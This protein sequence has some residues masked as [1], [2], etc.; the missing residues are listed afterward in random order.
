MS[1]KFIFLD[2][3]LVHRIGH[4]YEY[5]LNIA[6][7]FILEGWEVIFFSNKKSTLSSMAGSPVFKH[8]SYTPTDKI[9]NLKI[10]RPLIKIFAHWRVTGNELQRALD[11]MDN[12]NSIFF[13]QHV[14]CYM[15]PGI[16]Q[17][18][19]N[20]KGKLVLMLRIT[21]ENSNGQ[22]TLKSVLYKVFLYLL[23][24]Y[25]KEKLILVT[26]SQR[27]LSEFK[28]LT[29]HEIYLL[30]IPNI[31][32]VIGYREQQKSKLTVLLAG[33]MSFEKGIQYI[34][35]LVE[36]ARALNLPLNFIIHLYAPPNENEVY[37]SI[38]SKMESLEA[39]DLILTKLPLSSN[40]Y[41]D[42]IKSADIMLLLYDGYRYR[43]QTSGLFLDALSFGLYPIVSADTWLADMVSSSCFGTVIPKNNRVQSTLSALKE[44]TITRNTLMPPEALELLEWH[45]SKTFYST[46]KNLIS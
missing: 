21:A 34:P 36:A 11:R 29:K 4:A 24:N 2:P 22:L 19:F 8:F 46:L 12:F 27:L 15:L 20:S 25:L 42:Q 16:F 6:K 3:S 38:K 14:E 28:K 31:P 9:L 7:E 18:F 33:R 39:E 40:K 5:D 1:K 43:N 26:D 41:W 37:S 17:A 10:L 44:L 45:N 23:S 13:I 30:P 32:K 35:E